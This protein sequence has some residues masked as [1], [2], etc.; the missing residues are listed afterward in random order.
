MFVR[1]VEIPFKFDLCVMPGLL[2]VVC[3]I[4]I[5]T[6][7]KLLYTNNCNAVLLIIVTLYY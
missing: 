1:V 3:G 2:F 4:E 7:L 5:C 6:N